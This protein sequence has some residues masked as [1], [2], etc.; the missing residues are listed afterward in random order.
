V[1]KLQRWT[2]DLKL[3]LERDIRELERQIKEAKRA[4]SLALS[5]EEKLAGQKQVKT[6]EAQRNQKRRSLFD[7]QDKVD[8]RREKLIAEVEA[9]L[10]Q[11]T[12]IE[13]LFSIRWRYIVELPKL[14][15]KEHI[16]RKSVSAANHV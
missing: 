5:L 7:A 3:T 11:Q 9:K 1:D 16:E 4:A 15:T 14:A 8:D 6:L 2:D 13:N 12:V 10:A